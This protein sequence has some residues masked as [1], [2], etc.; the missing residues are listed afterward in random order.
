MRAVVIG[1]RAPGFHDGVRLGQRCELT[2]VRALIPEPPVKRFNKG[3]FHG[4]ASP[5][6][7]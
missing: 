1:I 4:I 3:I 2:R 6:K 7:I 5:N